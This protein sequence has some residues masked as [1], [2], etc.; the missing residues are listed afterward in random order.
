VCVRAFKAPCGQNLLN[1]LCS[2]SAIL[3]TI[4][5]LTFKNRGALVIFLHRCQVQVIF[6]HRSHLLAVPFKQ[7]IHC[8]TIH[9][10]LEKKTIFYSTQTSS[11]S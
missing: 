5:L 1:I 10:K 6:Q 4:G 11:I 7:Y 9:V 2:F 8:A 3:L